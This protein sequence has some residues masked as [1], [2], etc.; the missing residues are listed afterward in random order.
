MKWYP[1]PNTPFEANEA[2]QIRNPKT[3]RILQPTYKSKASDTRKRFHSAWTV[4][5]VKSSITASWA[6][7]ILSAK[8]GRPL[9]SW[10]DACH[11]NGVNSDDRM[12]NLE[13]KSRL[14]NIIDEY[15]IGR[16]LELPNEEIDKAIA[17]LEALKK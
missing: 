7:L 15:K 1:V 11:V 5:G 9:L 14:R 17:E 3:D 2:G 4:D 10:E 8:L 16:L 13:A 6:R 12:E